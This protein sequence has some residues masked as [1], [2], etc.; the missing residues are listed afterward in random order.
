MCTMCYAR[1]MFI[2]LLMGYMNFHFY[3]TILPNMLQ[4]VVYWGFPLLYVLFR[5]KDVLH[6]WK[7]IRNKQY[8]LYGLFMFMLAFVWSFFVIVINDSSDWSYFHILET[9]IH[10][11]LMSIA[12]YL[13]LSDY[14]KRNTFICTV[15]HILLLYFYV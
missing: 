4:K 14:N 12:F 2:V 5:Y 7:D 6:I 10:Y 3:V 1:Y 11:I 13:L 8:I 15:L 9:V